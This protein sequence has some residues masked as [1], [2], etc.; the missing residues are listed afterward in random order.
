MTTN[1]NTNA[2]S[3]LLRV[4]ARAIGVTLDAA[5]AVQL[6][7]YRDLLRTWNARFN[8]TAITDDEGMRVRHFVDS[9][10]ALHVLPGG[11]LTVLDVGSGAG[12]PGIPLKIARPD[13]DVTLMDSTGKKVTFCEQVIQELGLRGIRALKARAEEV[14]HQSDQRERYDVVIA[15]ALAALP[16]LLEYLL[17]FVRVGG[18]CI[19]MKGAD[20]EAEAAQAA[21]ALR[22]LGGELARVEPVTLPGLPDARALVIV[23]KVR[24]TPALYPRAA[25]KPRNAPLI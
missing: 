4:A 11:R 14:A 1:T 23:R 16:T 6:L 7:R 15:R 3:E 18:L 12:L 24:P 25:G 20:A 9:L 13:L 10:S 8:L 19:A 5:Q 21:R 17:P 22:T 2:E